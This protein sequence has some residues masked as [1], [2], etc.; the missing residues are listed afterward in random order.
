MRV[1]HLASSFPRWD[2]DHHAPYLGDLVAAQAERGMDPHVLVPHG[3]GLPDD[4]VVAG[5]PVHRFR[6][7]PARVEV[8]AYRGGLMRT[9]TTPAGAAALPGFLAAFAAAAVAAGR[10]LRPAVIHAH[11]WLPA[12]V[13]GTAAARAGSAPLVVTAH[14]SDVHLARRRGLNRLAGGVLRRAAVVGA[15]SEALASDLRAL[16]PGLAVDVLRMPVLPGP[17]AGSALPPHPPIRLL[18]AGR[19]MPEKG[20]DV[21]IRAVARLVSDGVDVRLR[22]VGDGPLR[23]ALEG[24]AAAA[25]DAIELT[26]PGPKEYL[27]EAMDAAHAVVVPS[28]REG[29]GLI[30][31]EAVARGRPVIASAVGGLPEAVRAPDDG[32]LVPPDDV[33]ALAEAIRRLPLP[34]PVG[35]AAAAHAPAA[36]VAA[37][38]HAYHRACESTR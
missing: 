22:V 21:A 33:D 13:A 26:P 23:A 29:L 18:V 38:A 31:L 5:V 15:V 19:L 11:W 32:L 2:G 10:R 4:A 7:A 14:G 17:G 35:T 34:P 20:I 30:A 6:Y 24:L 28:R 27:W 36:V 12:G 25:G 37:H 1:L 16:F 3:P 8:L 9:A